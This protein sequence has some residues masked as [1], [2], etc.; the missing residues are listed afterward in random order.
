MIQRLLSGLKLIESG[1]L[2]GILTAMILLAAYQVLARNFFDTGL[3]WG[4]SLVRV[5][6]LWI[7]FVGA[8]I[9]A[10]QDD[11]IRIDLLTRFISASSNAWL[12]RFRSL[13]TAVIAGAF[14]W[15]SFHFVLL[16]YQDGIIAFAGV[17]AWICE[18]VMPLGSAVIGLRYLI[19]AFSPS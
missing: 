2:V 10:R 16:D 12:V 17:P 1:L 8:T 18:L 15:Y 14:A 3:M 5:L 13:F 9:A 19:R 11:H 7:T 4:E 6:V